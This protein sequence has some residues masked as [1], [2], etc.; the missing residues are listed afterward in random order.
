MNGLKLILAILINGIEVRRGELFAR[1]LTLAG[2][3]RMPRGEIQAKGNG[4]K[5]YILLD[6]GEIFH[7]RDTRKEKS[8]ERQK[9]KICQ[10]KELEKSAKN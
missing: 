10:L 6:K 7:Q 4:V 1:A 9:G 2:T 3:G 5:N 8:I